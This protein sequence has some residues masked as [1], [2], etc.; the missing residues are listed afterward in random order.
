MLGRPQS[1]G[2]SLV[3]FRC[4]QADGKDEQEARPIVTYTDYKWSP[5]WS[6]TEVASM[7]KPDGFCPPLVLQQSFLAMTVPAVHCRC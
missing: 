4:K 3:P 7:L 2:Y 6:A 5:R 1:S